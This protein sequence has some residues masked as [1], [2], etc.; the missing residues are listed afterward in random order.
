MV[1]VYLVDP[2]LDGPRLSSQCRSPRLW[3][4]ALVMAPCHFPFP[5]TVRPMPPVMAL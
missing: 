1:H 5:V 4:L 3:P 2:H